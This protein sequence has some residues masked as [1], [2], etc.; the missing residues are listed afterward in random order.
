M[1]WLLLFLTPVMNW[2]PEPTSTPWHITASLPENG[3]A[4]LYPGYKTRKACEADLFKEGS[5]AVERFKAVRVYCKAEGTV[6]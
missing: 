4:T 5:K 1:K 3:I 2:T 6:A